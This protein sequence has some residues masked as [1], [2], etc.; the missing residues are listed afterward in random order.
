MKEINFNSRVMVVIFMVLTFAFGV[1]ARLYWVDWASD[2]PEMMHDGMLMINTNDGY[3]FAEG[4]RDII[5]GF[6]QPN[7]LSY[8]WSSLSKFTAF[9]YNVTPFEL[10][11]ILLYMSVFFSSLI[12]VPIILIAREF[13]AT[14]AGFIAAA[15]AVVAV[16]YYNRTMAGYYD[17]D[18]LNIV[19]PVFVLWGFIRVTV[20]QDRFSIIIAPL[21]SLAYHWWYASSFTLVAGMVGIFFLY[22]LV[23]ERKSL[24]NYQTLILLVIS[25]TNISPAFRLALI[26]VLYIVFMKKEDMKLTA[27]LGLLTFLLFIAKGGLNPVWFMLKFYVVRDVTE[28]S[29]QNFHF[30]SVNQTIQ[31]SG[32]MDWDYFMTRISSHPA[33]FILGILGYILF[34][35]KHKAFLISLPILGLG[36][37]SVKSGLRFTIYATPIMAL[38]LGFFVDFLLNQFKIKG[39]LKLGCIIVFSAVA[40]WPAIN[41]IKNYKSPTVFFAPEVDVLEKLKAVADRED[42]AIAWWDYGYPIRY[43]ADVKTLID[44]GKHLGNHNFPVSFALTKDMVSSANMSRLAVEYTEKQFRDKNRTSPLKSMMKDYNFSDPNLFLTSLSLKDFNLPTKTR[45]IYYYLPRRMI[46]IYNVISL[47]SN[48]DLTTGKSNSQQI[49]T[50]TRFVKSNNEGL[51]LDNGMILTVDMK[52]IVFS[53]QVIP[54]KAI[55]ETKYDENDKFSLNEILV[56]KD[57]NLNII[58]LS[59][60]TFVILDNEAFKSAYVQL[61]MLERYDPEIFELTISTPVAKVYKLKR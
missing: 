45:D 30:F 55:Y 19:L 25:L 43:Y 26:A 47:F 50:S 36:L 33:F 29:S 15:A 20:K 39:F 53:S 37:L 35:F 54:I 48:L 42:Y 4:A 56:N 41:H 38:G 46:D 3:A 32:T 7:D 18:M 10:E 9:L 12:V 17:T 22:T 5:A 11:T 59:D 27:I 58:I 61:F 28:V 2:F 44:G 8:V 52:N 31:E 57:G 40:V 34:C 6:H 60:G 1:V 51:V 16:S 21:F 14:E 49:F 23:F 13:K 24:Q